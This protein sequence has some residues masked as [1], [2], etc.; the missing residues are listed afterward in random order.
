[1]GKDRER[2]I[3]KIPALNI[4]TLIAFT[5]I[6]AD[7]SETVVTLLLLLEIVLRFATDWRNFFKT[8]SNWV[9]LALAVIT[10]IMQIPAIR[11]SGKPYAWL[12][13]FQIVRIYRVVLAVSLTRDL[14][15]STC[16]PPPS[17]SLGSLLLDGSAGQCD[18]FA[19]LDHLRVPSHFLDRY[20]C[21]TNIPR[22]DSGRRR[23]REY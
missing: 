5:D 19:E 20:L 2:F 21:G 16:K 8:K 1:M 22:P 10:T 4:T 11:H 23:P 6:P 12:T 9:D 14:I 18:R 7:A 17:Q 13:F 15:V 3:S